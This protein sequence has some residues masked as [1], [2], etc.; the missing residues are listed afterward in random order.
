L[1]DKWQDPTPSPEL[2]MRE[3]LTLATRG[4]ALAARRAGVDVVKA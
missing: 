4:K 3:G 2:A 1:E